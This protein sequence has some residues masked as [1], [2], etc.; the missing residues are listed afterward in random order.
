MSHITLIRH[1]QANSGAKDELSY[2]RLS[3]LG[4]EQAGWLGGYLSDSATHHTRL[5]TGTL[6][7]HIETADGMQTGLD[8]VRDPR[9][10]ELEYFTMAKLLEEQHGIDFPTEQGQFTSHLPTVFAYWKDGKIED[11][12]ETWNQFHTRV[13]DALQEIAAGNG[14][15]LVVTSGGLISM[16]MSQAMHLDIPAMARLALA[17]MHTSMHR[18]FPIGGH[19]SPV[20]FNAVP[21]LE[22][23]DRRVAQTH[24]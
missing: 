3:A 22:T 23:P 12:P 11:T 21:H 15:A 24:I 10:N 20:L 19:W 7:R 5:Y 9:L 14:P 16:A 13:N 6:R 1:G 2:D 18:L 4:H 17:I 8:A